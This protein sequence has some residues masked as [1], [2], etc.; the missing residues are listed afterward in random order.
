MGISRLSAYRVALHTAE[1]PPLRDA[2]TIIRIGN[3]LMTYTFDKS[4][5]TD[6]T[7]ETRL[8]VGDAV[9][10]AAEAGREP[11]LED[12]QDAVQRVDRIGSWHETLSVVRGPW[13]VVGRPTPSATDNG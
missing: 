3:I 4:S 1:L 7:L 10:V 2:E 6:A 8:G 9:L 13:S 12:R 5:G 11:S